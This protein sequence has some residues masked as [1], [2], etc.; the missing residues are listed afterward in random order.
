MKLDKKKVAQILT[1]KKAVLPCHRCGSKTFSI[2]DDY[3]K[4]QIQSD[5]DKIADTFVG[6]PSVPA[7]VVACNN[8]GAIT[9]H[10][11]GA[12]GLLSAPKE[13]ENAEKKAN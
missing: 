3:T 2:L 12:L 4:I 7:I 13:D 6:G 9:F 5:L 8:C 11:L 10:A 1:E